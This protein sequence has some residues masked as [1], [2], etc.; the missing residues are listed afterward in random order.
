VSPDILH[1]QEL[2]NYSASEA[3]DLIASWFGGDWYGAQVE[4][5]N[6]YDDCKTISRYPIIDSWAIDGNLA[7]LIDTTESIGTPILCINAHLPCCNNDSGRQNE[8]DAIVAFIRD[9]YLPDG[10]LTLDSEVPVMVAGDLNLVGLSQQ[11]VTLVTG[12]IQNEF[13][14]GPDSPPDPDGSDLHSITSRQTEKRMGY[15][16][17]NDPNNYAGYWPGQLDFLIY[18]DSNLTLT[19]DFIVYTPEMSPSELTANSLMISDSLVSDH[20]V[21]CADFAPPCSED[22]TSDGTIDVSDLLAII[23]AWGLCLGCDED[24]NEDAW[25]D[26]ADLLIIIAAWGPCE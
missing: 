23:N 10:V 15:T 14:H 7:V 26:V 5:G 24:I 13:E 4:N 3:T 12:D 18:S 25:V 8:V 22:V 6:S 9:A 17:R 16:W 11:L 21:F 2:S 1:L 19:R 20:L